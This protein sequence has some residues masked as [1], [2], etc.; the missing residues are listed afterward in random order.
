MKKKSQ[1]PLLIASTTHNVRDSKSHLSFR[2]F[3][4]RKYPFNMNDKE[5]WEKKR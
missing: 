2:K 5:Y 1:N 3:V 4:F